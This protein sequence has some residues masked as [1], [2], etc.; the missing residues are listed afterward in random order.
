MLQ[1]D[2]EGSKAV[3]F[4][5]H[6]LALTINSKIYHKLLNSKKKH[7]NFNQHITYLLSLFS[8]I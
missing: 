7:D 5:I 6:K 1:N 2:D 3:F 8:V 4:E